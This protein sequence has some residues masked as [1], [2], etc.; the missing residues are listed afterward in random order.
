MISIRYTS[1]LLFISCLPVVAQDNP[2]DSLSFQKARDLGRQD[3][4]FLKTD[5]SNAVDTRKTPKANLSEY[6]KTLYPLL[7]KSCLACHGPERTEGRLRIDQLN[8]NLLTGEHVNQWKEVYNAL[9]NSEMPP[10]DEPEFE[11]ADEDRGTLVEWVGAELEKAYRVRKNSQA[12][13]SFRRMTRYEYNYALQDLLGFPFDMV[14]R[15]PPESVSEDGFKNRSEMLQMSAMQFQT[16]REIGLKTLR[17]ITVHGE[18][19]KPVV[20]RFPFD[21]EISRL[22]S[23]ANAK[24]FN[25]KDDNYKQHRNNPHLLNQSSGQAIHYNGGNFKPDP[26]AMVGEAHSGSPIVISLPPGKE[27]KFNLDRFLPDD[28]IMRVRIRAARSNM[29][30]EH[31]ASLRLI[32]SAHTSNNANFSQEISQ[33]DLPVTAP[34]ESPE[35]IDFFISLGDIQRNPFRKLETTFPRRDEFL[36]IRNISNGN[37]G[38]DPLGVLIDQ[39]EISAPFYAQWPPRSHQ[40]IFF[41]SANRDKEDVYAAEVLKVFMGRAWRRTVGE[42]EVAQFVALFKRFR[43]DFETFEEAM[44]EVLATVIASPEFLYLTQRNDSEGG[45][46]TRQISEMEFATRLS[47][48]LWSSIP[49]VELLGVA[50][51]G[52]LRDPEV[53]KAQVKRMLSDPRANRFAEHFVGQWLGL[54][55]LESVTHIR[56]VALKK[57]MHEEPIA[58]FK[59]VLRNNDS[60]MDFLHSDYVVINERLAGHYRIGNVYGTHFRRVSVEPGANRGGVLTHAGMLAMNSDGTDSHPLKRGIWMLERILQDPPPPPPPN[61]PEVDLTDPRILQMTLKERIEDHRNKPACKSCHSKID[62]WG[63]AFEN[64]DALGSFRTQLK[65]GPVDSSAELFNKQPL[66]GMAGLKQYLLLERQ[67]QFS[68]AIAEK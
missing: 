8:P 61:V 23:A 35:Y 28:G 7:Q 55:G 53:L 25:K 36:H 14:E 56:D 66:D 4:R 52:E 15:L 9:G 44:Q 54:D 59:E 63:I 46:G 34:Q 67:D 57:A 21:G 6:K 45:K 30:P 65:N 37:R 22:T 48:F 47:F 20:Y 33:R 68:H 58:F 51:Q 19:P 31:F 16:S 43:L 10:A 24:V 32:F 18:Q 5:A 12:Y 41:D 49:D 11:L 26:N 42:Q 62:P 13:S 39:I 60:V 2:S 17:R 3:S 27:L 40:N 50:H 29:N 1:L 38:A 64:Y